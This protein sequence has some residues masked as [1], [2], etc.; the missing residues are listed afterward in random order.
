MKKYIIIAS[1][2]IGLII[3]FNLCTFQVAENKSVIVLRFGKI[4]SVYVKNNA[5]KLREDLTKGKFDNVKVVQGTGLFF[6]LPF[7]DN[8]KEYS[9][10]LLTYD[11]SPRQVITSDKKK[12]IFDNNAQ[13]T[14]SNP[15]FF[16]ISMGRIEAAQ[17]RLDDIV[18]SKMNEKVGKMDSHDLIT[19]KILVQTMQDDLTIEVSKSVENFGITVKDIR[20]K[21]TDY[22]QE[23]Y[24]SI[25]R[26]MTTERERMAAQYISEGEEEALKI[27]SNTDKEVTI[28]TSEA[29]KLAEILKGEG[30]GQAAKIYNDAYG[31]DAN[32]FEFYNTLDAYR[33]TIGKNTK[34]VIPSNSPFAKYLLGQK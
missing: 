2:F 19:N 20:V 6:K 13:W 22:P 34:L 29:S 9:N 33:T 7:I 1:I 12:L 11:T 21:R 24:E 14:I 17:T 3:A 10:M 15:V 8:V 25:Y 16:E 28:L 26:R 5:D 31:K 30:D 32:F 4:E 18:Y 27:R 23:N